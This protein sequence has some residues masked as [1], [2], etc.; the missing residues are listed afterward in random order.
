MKSGQ[1]TKMKRNKVTNPF[2]SGNNLAS[3]CQTSNVRGLYLIQGRKHDW[4]F[5]SI[6]NII[7]CFLLRLTST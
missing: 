2:I 6:E 3:Y 7:R 5:F 1:I 4:I